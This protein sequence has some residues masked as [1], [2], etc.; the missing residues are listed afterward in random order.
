LGETPLPSIMTVGGAT[1]LQRRG[2]A[3]EWHSQVVI[4]AEK[5]GD[6]ERRQPPSTPQRA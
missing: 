3:L 4:T 6:T 2:L 5:G 1:P